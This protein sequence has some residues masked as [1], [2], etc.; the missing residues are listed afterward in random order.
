MRSARGYTDA[1]AGDGT[2]PALVTVSHARGTRPLVHH[3]RHSPT[4]FSWGYG[5]SG[6]ADLA[7]SILADY[8]G[9]VPEPGLYQRF[10]FSVVAHWPIGAR[11]TLDGGAIAAWLAADA[12]QQP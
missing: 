3:V 8:L 9:Y 2:G 5:D 11:W 4:G 1:Q 10:K 12:A 7:R 6:P